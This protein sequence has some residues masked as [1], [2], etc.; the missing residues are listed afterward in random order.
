MPPSQTHVPHP[1]S[2][3]GGTC[4]FGETGAGFDGQHLH[5]VGF[6][7]GLI[8]RSADVIINDDA[9]APLMHRNGQRRSVRITAMC[10]AQLM[11]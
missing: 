3:S 2:E 6:A 11:P 4:C 10:T 9:A 1:E 7:A 5:P 8:V